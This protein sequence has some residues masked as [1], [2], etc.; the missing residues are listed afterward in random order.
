MIDGHG[1]DRYNYGDQV[2]IDFSSNIAFNNRATL[3]L[4]H[5]AA[6]LPSV[7]NYPDP[8]ATVLSKKI[9]LHHSVNPE[10]VLLTNGSA[11][12]FYVA[13]HLLRSEQ[14]RTLILTPSFAEYEDSC[15]AFGHRIDKRPLADFENID[16]TPYR[17]VW[18]GSPNN[19]DGQRVPIEMI[20]S[21]ADAHPHCSFLVDRAYNEL[22]ASSES[23]ADSPLP[24]NLMLC[25]S[26]TKAFG[27][28]GLRIGYIV[29][30]SSIIEKMNSLKTPWSVSSLALIAGEYIMDN[31]AELTM[32]KTELIGESL[33]LQRA[34]SKQKS[35][36]VTPSDCNFFLC[37]LTNG[38]TASELHQY[39]VEQ[40]GILIRNASNFHG[41]TPYHF[42][43]SVQSKEDNK[44]LIEALKQW[45]I[46]HQ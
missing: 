20:K 28:P 5:L 29:A 33:S 36:H 18:I 3:I 46:I 10:N 19:P 34:I 4:H 7:L 38:H 11:E 1:N 16:F 12:A 8:R 39:L 24:S 25:Y 15:K 27:I 21:I 23:Y 44:H 43:I 41:L 9:A 13:A 35:I 37:K 31:Y 14:L 6:H 40:H 45:L 26:L 22:S 2:R 17:S 30:E 42:R 32:D